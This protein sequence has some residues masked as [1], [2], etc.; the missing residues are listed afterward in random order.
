MKKIC[1]HPVNTHPRF[2]IGPFFSLGISY[3]ESVQGN[4]C[5]ACKKF[6]TSTLDVHCKEKEH[7]EN[8]EKIVK[9]KKA[10]A[11]EKEMKKNQEEQANN[12]GSG[13]L[14]RKNPDDEDSDECSDDDGNWKRK[15]KANME[16]VID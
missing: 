2:F 13:T 15:R 10:K 16:I 11:L 9:G 4:Y 14:K 12:S 6:I 5:T 8:F 3:C 7:Y 1:H